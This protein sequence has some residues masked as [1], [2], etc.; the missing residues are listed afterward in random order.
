MVASL[1][2]RS[3]VISHRALELDFVAEIVVVTLVQEGAMIFTVVAAENVSEVLVVDIP[4][5]EAKVTEPIVAEHDQV[6]PVSTNQEVEDTVRESEAAHP[7][8]APAEI[9]NAVRV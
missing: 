5:L 3:L 2:T 8:T 7:K 1:N 6:T 9:E 4:A